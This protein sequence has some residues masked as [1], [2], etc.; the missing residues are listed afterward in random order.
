MRVVPAATPPAGGDA[1]F[2]WFCGGDGGRGRPSGSEA[3]KVDLRSTVAVA[4]ATSAKTSLMRC[5]SSGSSRHRVL[6]RGCDLKADS[7]AYPL[8]F[9]HS[10][11]HN[12]PALEKFPSQTACCKEVL[13]EA[14]R[15]CA[16]GG[17]GIA[18]LLA[19]CKFWTEIRG[20]YRPSW[21]GLSRL[22][23]TLTRPATLPEGL[24]RG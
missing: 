20:K 5:L 22:R 4:A 1:W 11:W 21:R 18:S 9:A 19:P 2:Y 13:L 15:D 10:F 3:E 12:S 24:R 8:D 6:L 7:H 14:S 23:F 17:V 16:A